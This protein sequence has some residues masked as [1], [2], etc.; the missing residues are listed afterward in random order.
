MARPHDRGFV[1]PTF[2][3]AGGWGE[4]AWLSCCPLPA[5]TPSR[6][7][8]C[9]LTG[10]TPLTSP[11]AFARPAPSPAVVPRVPCGGS[12]G[13]RAAAPGTHLRPA[14]LARHDAHVSKVVPKRGQT[15]SQE[16]AGRAI[17]CRDV[18][19]LAVGPRSSGTS[20]RDCRR[21]RSVLT[22]G[23][24]SFPGLRSDVQWVSA[25]IHFRRSSTAKIVTD[26]GVTLSRPGRNGGT[27]REAAADA[28]VGDALQAPKRGGRERLLSALCVPAGG[29]HDG[30]RGAGLRSG[31]RAYSV[32]LDRE[33]KGPQGG[34]QLALG[35]GPRPHVVCLWSQ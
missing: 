29:G 30:H 11:S 32:A 5:Q 24:I 15:T 10:L 18:A 20:K 12:G 16:R 31:R 14:S 3:A 27:T 2:P 34:R 17:E 26:N 13:Q 19:I 8:R 22:S 25:R 23:C 4:C 1:E 21:R 28:A 35:T 6:A 33:L 9:A 7:H